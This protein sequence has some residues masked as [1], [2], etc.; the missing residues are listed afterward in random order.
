MRLIRICLESLNLPPGLLRHGIHREI[1]GVA[2]AD[3]YKSFLNGEADS[4]DYYDL[5]I[6][7]LIDFFKERWLLPRAK[8][9]DSYHSVKANGTLSVLCK[10][11][12]M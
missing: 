10:F 11:S 6:H 3:N 1:Y 2:L 9:I 5:P 7:E 8:R 4:I 12:K